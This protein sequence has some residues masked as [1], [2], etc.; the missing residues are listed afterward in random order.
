MNA[1]E[2]LWGE[3]ASRQRRLNYMAAMERLHTQF[4]G[5]DEVKT[6]YALEILSALSPPPPP[7]YLVPL[8]VRRTS[9]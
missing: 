6:F 7:S 1:V 9:F 2:D 8:F 5:D 3:G 4:P